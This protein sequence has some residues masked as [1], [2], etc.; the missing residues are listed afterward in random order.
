[1]NA[2]E[3]QGYAASRAIMRHHAHTF[4]YAARWL[5]AHRRRATH[6]LYA[7]FR[8]LDDLVDQVAAGDCPRDQARAE[9]NAWRRWLCDP[10]RFARTEPMVP[11]VLATMRD[12]S[13]SPVWFLDLID[14][15]ETDLDGSRYQTFADL[16][17]YC[18]RVAATVGLAMCSVLDARH[19]AAAAYAAELGVAMQLTNIL[20]DVAEDFAAGRVYLP[21]DQLAAAG[22]DDA[23][24][25]AGQPDER[26]RAMIAGLIARARL[27]YRRG[28]RGLPYLSPDGRFAILVAARCYAGILDEIERANY[29]V[30]ERRAHV[31][32]ARKITIALRL[33]ARSG[34]ARR[35]PMPPLPLDAPDGPRLLKLAASARGNR[36]QAVA[37]G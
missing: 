4:Y 18:Y 29:N 36:P 34:P 3:Q 27:Y 17:L 10:V 25:A 32:M 6:A 22:W 5:P 35:E 16:T 37:F 23:S 1:M 11:A 14:G 13:V 12:F 21:A 24:L 7:L 33:A 30:F 31:S 19:P 28:E 9:L 2:D 26:F 8:T 15:L 20:R